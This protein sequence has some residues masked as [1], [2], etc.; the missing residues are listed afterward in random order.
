MYQFK[1]L[2][3]FTILFIIFLFISCIRDFGTNIPDTET[4]SLDYTKSGGFGGINN[5]LTIS[6]SDSV[7]Y[8]ARDYNFSTSADGEEINYL[9]NI[10]QLNSFFSM[11]SEFLPDQ[12]VADDII[13]RISYNSDSKSHTIIASGYC[14]NSKW[15]KGLIKIVDYLEGYVME[16]KSKIN[17][18]KVIVTSKMLL[19]EWPF[20]DRI[21]LSDHLHKNVDVDEEIFKHIREPSNQDVKV[22]FFEGEWIYRLNVSNHSGELSSYYISIHDRNKPILWP[23]E[24]KLADIPENGINLVRQDYIW[25]KEKL[26]EIHYPRYFIDGSLEPGEYIYEIH[27]INGN[28]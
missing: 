18:G 1:T 16:L 13:F 12:H 28:N 4:F 11:D 7:I 2:I 5:T 15:P 19:E 3:N 20:S 24:P 23:F 17:S 10:L 8:L 14:S 25:I 27:L 21:K 9:F 22:S 6:K 26:K